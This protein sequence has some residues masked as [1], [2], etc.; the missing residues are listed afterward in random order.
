M[1]AQEPRT[2][3]KLPGGGEA[4]AAAPVIVSASRVTDI[5]SF[6]SRWLMSR[7]EAGWCQRRNP[8]SGHPSFIS[9]ENCRAIV[10][11]TK[12]PSPM[13]PL[14][15]RLD[16]LGFNYYFLF[17]LNF[18]EGTGLEPR[19]R[20]FGKR[21]ETF[22]ALSEALGPERVI[23][24]FDPLILAPGMNAAELVD[25]V[26]TAGEAIFGCTRRLVTSFADIRGYPKVR[27]NLAEAGIADDPEGC[28]LSRD[29]MLEAAAGIARLRDGWAARGWDLEVATCA[30]PIDL[31]CFG[32]VRG[33]CIDAELMKRLWPGDEK[34][35]HYLRTGKA[36]L[37]GMKP[38][39][40]PKSPPDLKDP[41]QRRECRCAR[42]RD[43]GGTSCCPHLCAYCYAN[44]SKAEVAE[45]IRQFDPRMAKL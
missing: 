10:F 19:L 17:T 41:S 36:L 8:Y 28:E 45:K 15:P 20:P 11:W 5:P 14:L 44:D 42:S 24:R 9:F 43:I 25:R 29:Q 33:A 13:I 27:R 7:L 6:Y 30:E 31:D 38:L 22:R 35:M 37:D 18:Y 16:A 39:P 2:S 32:I 4:S 12:D 34:L 23:W 3:I 1:K 40:D 21:A 26:R